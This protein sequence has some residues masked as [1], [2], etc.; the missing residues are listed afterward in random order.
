MRIETVTVPLT[1]DPTEIIM[2]LATAFEAMSTTLYAE[3]EVFING[4]RYMLR[5]TP[6]QERAS[7]K[8]TEGTTGDSSAIEEYL[9]ELHDGYVCGKIIEG[10]N[11]WAI[12][13]DQDARGMFDICCESVERG[14]VAS[15]DRLLKLN[16]ADIGYA[17]RIIKL[18]EPTLQ[19]PST[20]IKRPPPAPKTENEK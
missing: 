1:S 17:D 7:R 12:H 15:G 16:V 4:R 18:G 11:G 20:P 14:V 8:W 5:L 10:P 6:I 2:Q 9:L 13:Y 19:T 3:Q